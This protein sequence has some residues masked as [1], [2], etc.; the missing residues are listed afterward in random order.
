MPVPPISPTNILEE[1]SKV[2]LTPE[3]KTI[4][5]DKD[6]SLLADLCRFQ[7]ILKDEGKESVTQAAIQHWFNKAHRAE[8]K[9]RKAKRFLNGYLQWLESRGQRLSETQRPQFEA[10]Q[11]YLQPFGTPPLKYPNAGGAIET[12]PEGDQDT[13]LQFRALEGTYQLI[14]ANSSLAERYVLEPLTISVDETSRTA[15][16]QMF[17]HNQRARDF[18]YEG[19]LHASY[20]YGYCLVRRRHEK[21]PN[22]FALRCITFFVN[23]EREGDAY[24]SQP[25][26]SGIIS[27]GVEGKIGRLRMIAVPFIALKA[28]GSLLNV[29]EAEFDILKG[30]D[31]RRLHDSSDILVGLV[32]K[33]TPLFQFCNRI[34]LKLKKKLVTGFVL[35]TVRSIEIENA[36]KSN[37]ENPDALFSAW[38]AAVNAH[39]KAKRVGKIDRSKRR[40]KIAAHK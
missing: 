13:L 39:L 3:E 32:S 30:H 2:R 15:T 38:Q 8:P 37:F 11:R 40:R 26:I 6:E 7:E 34:F 22:R 4:G 23:S 17:S 1:I 16:V 21:N 12:W 31:L 33:P 28:P 9:H 27:R 20:N 18:I 35:H 10:L 25:C 24:V 29:K 19:V 5:V 14:R 36:I